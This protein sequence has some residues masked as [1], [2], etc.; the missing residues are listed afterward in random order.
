MKADG[1]TAVTGKKNPETRA[2]MSS[3]KAEIDK[4]LQL[5][6]APYDIHVERGALYI[7]N[8]FVAGNSD[9][10]TKPDDIRRNL[11]KAINAAR[12]KYPTSKFFK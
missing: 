11:I 1:V 8:H 10:M 9:A 7:G 6:L 4:Y 5:E 12:A 2:L 3:I